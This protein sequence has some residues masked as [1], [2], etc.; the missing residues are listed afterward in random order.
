VVG[1]VGL[2]NTS[3][4]TRLTL[5]HFWELLSFLVNSLVFLVIGLTISPADLTDELAAVVIAV[6]GVIVVRVAL[7]YGLAEVTERLLPRRSIP[8]RYRH[9]MTWGGLRGAISLALVLTLTAD[10]VGEETEQTIRVMT[11]GVV[12]FTLLIQGTT[13]SGVIRRLGLAGKA[14]NEL[15]QQHHQ[16]RIAMARGG[17]SEVARL[18]AE[19]VLAGDLAAAIGRTY[20]RDVTRGTAAL[21]T[22]LREHP[23]LEVAML[24]QARRDAIFAEQRALSDLVRSGLIETEVAADLGTELSE[25]LAALDLLEERWESDDVPDGG[26]V[27][28]A[29]SVDSDGSRT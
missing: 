23:E 16:A 25:R 6:V 3:P 20:Q 14:D 2:R 29:A 9:V 28:E 4:S 8:T 5:E 26:P 17:Q 24:L 18:G 21:Q 27:V 12:L 13:I 22:H 15:A 10:K 11:F 1:T 19:G 7:V